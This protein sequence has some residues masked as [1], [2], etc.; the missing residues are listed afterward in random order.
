M[1]PQGGLV[2]ERVPHLEGR[3]NGSA[4]K[5]DL[6]TSMNSAVIAKRKVAAQ[7]VTQEA[8]QDNQPGN[9]GLGASGSSSSSG[10]PDLVDVENAE[11]EDT[12]F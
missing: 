11:L 8:T 12:A 6:L 5:S 4:T 2:L 3:L 9:V 1:I 7:P 10:A